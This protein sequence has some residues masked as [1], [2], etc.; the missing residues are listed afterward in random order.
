MESDKI[1]SFIEVGKDKGK[2]SL[3]Q[4]A[5]IDTD[6]IHYVNTTEGKR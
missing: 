3:I 2:H 6:K 4:V 5:N 1:K